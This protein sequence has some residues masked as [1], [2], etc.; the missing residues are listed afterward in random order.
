[1]FS[2][3]VTML[4][5][6]IYDLRVFLFFYLIVNFLFSLLFSVLGVG[7]KNIEGPFKEYV[8]NLPEDWAFNVPN[9]EYDQIGMFLGNIVYVMR[10]SIGD[11]DFEASTY[12]SYEENL[13]FWG[14]WTFI[15]IM[16]CI[17]FLNFIISEIG[18]S[19]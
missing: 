16:T 18:N 13:I 1:M 15:V 3:I 6:V 4:S 12:L 5:S 14:M 9:E 17:I 19:Y 8:D 7:N 2:Y 11:F 10:S